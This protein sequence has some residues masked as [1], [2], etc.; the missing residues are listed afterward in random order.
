MFSGDIILIEDGRRKKL[1]VKDAGGQL[2]HW[3][4]IEK[5]RNQGNNILFE[6]H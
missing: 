6:W 1:Y 5:M 3:S 2:F 4:D